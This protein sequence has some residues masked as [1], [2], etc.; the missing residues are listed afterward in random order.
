M[1]ICFNQGTSMKY[2]TLERD[3]ELAVQ[4]EYDMIEL[5]FDKLHDYM[6]RYKPEHLKNF[7]RYAFT[8]RICF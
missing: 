5:R 7:F 8:W 2:S 4:Y 3:L 6:R 1:K